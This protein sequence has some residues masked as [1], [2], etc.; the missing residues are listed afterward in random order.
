MNGLSS[1][2]RHLLSFAGSI[3]LA[4]VIIPAADAGCPYADKD[5]WRKAVP[6]KYLKRAEYAFVEANPA[7]PNVLIIGDSISM[8]YTTGVQKA[9]RGVANVCRAPDNCRSTRQTLE[10]IETYLGEVDWDLIHFNWG[11]HDLTHL[12]PD[13]RSAP[14]PKGS[15]QVPLK[16]YRANVNKLVARLK[17]TGARL[18]WA[19]TTPIASKSEKTGIRRD[20][21]VVTYNAAALTVVESRRI[22]VN[23]LYSLAKP[24][25]ESLFPDGVHPNSDGSRLLARAVASAIRAQLSEAKNVRNTGRTLISTIGSE[26]ATQGNGN[27]IVTVGANTHVVWQDS[28]DDGYFARVRSLDRKTGKWSEAY[29]LGKGRDNHARPTITAD[30]EG[31]LHV[32]IGGHH[33]GLQY[34]RSIRANDA[35]EWTAIEKFGRTTYP[36][37]LCG[38]DDTLYITG[39]H[40]KGWTGMDFYVKPHDKAWENRGLLV[41][42]HKRFKYYAAY[43]NA[44]AWGPE[45]KTLHMSVGFFLGDSKR[46]GEHNRD[47]QGLYQ[48]VGYMR[49]KDAGMTWH[50]ADETPI[51]LPATTDTIDLIDSG[52]REREAHDKPKPGIRH[53][54]IAVD[55]KDHP[56]VVYVRHT[57][58]PG[59]I[60]MVTPDGRGGWAK[61]PL[62]E[63]IEK[64]WPG[65]VAFDGRVSMTRDDVICLILTLAPRD[66]ANAN[67]NPGIHGR[68]DFWLR[69]EPNIQRLAWLESRDGGRTFSTRDVIPHR[70]DR[71]TLLPTLERPTGF[72]GPPTG[73]LPA[74]LYFEGLGRYRKPGELIQNDVIYV[75]P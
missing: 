4:F 42:K 72:H 61:R 10:H 5:A 11:I 34:R 70:P 39:R 18:I 55:S 23:D 37:L 62:C 66:H 63:A 33:D 69:E 20:R 28:I 47:P 67:W 60:E 1:C 64:H 19:T 24:K 14:A 31:F 40:D 6:K 48:A 25:A 74:L 52:E 36:I 16:T 3:A 41:K 13:G 51:E 7:L 50:Q 30:N 46:K 54:G 45:K 43:H 56:Y 38:P 32:I 27:K 68:P 35:S 59:A 73:E 9:L 21:D 29:T 65:M 2:L 26:R 58:E 57:P 44:M 15:H 12:G 8:R 17:T 53:L 49:S 75:Q 22:A 71:G